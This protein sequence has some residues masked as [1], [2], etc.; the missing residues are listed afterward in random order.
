MEEG[1]S[2][3]PVC[4]MIPIEVTKEHITKVLKFF[5]TDKL[6]VAKTYSKI[7][8][9]LPCAPNTIVIV[10]IIEITSNEDST[11]ELV[12]EA[13]VTLNKWL[14]GAGELFQTKFLR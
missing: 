13:L 9:N 14:P 8:L 12:N 10:T 2:K 3:S 6:S 4:V 11:L 7:L 1:K 5:N